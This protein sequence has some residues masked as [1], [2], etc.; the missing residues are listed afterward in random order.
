MSSVSVVIPCYNYGHFLEE[1][2]N[3][4]LHDQDGVE[5]RVLIVDDCSTDDSAQVAKR[6]AASDDR[7]ELVVHSENR[8]GTITCNFGLMEW[9]DGDYCIVLS[10]DDKL[11]PG[12]LPRAAD[13]MDAHPNVGFAYGHP[14]HFREGAPLPEARTK[15]SGWSIYPG[16]AW[17]ERRFR[18][19]TG[20]ITSPEVVVRTSLQKR[21]GGYDR[22]IY[23]AS[24]IEMWMRLAANA[25]V[26]YVRGADQAYYRIHGSNLSKQ[27]PR[28]VDLSQRK[29]AY[30]AILERYASTWP[31]ASHLADTVHRKLAWEALWFAA[32]AYD[33]GR[34]SETPVEDLVAFALDC[35]P[36]TEKMAAY[37]GLRLRQ[38]IGPAAMPYLQ[39]LI[40]TAVVRKA[41]DWWW[42]RSWERHGV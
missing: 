13:L 18:A 8:G 2:V 20:C 35:W 15:V 23:H 6:I 33:R 30:D 26:G 12:A 4:A 17:I 42:W 41:Q 22:R 29:L 34:V 28:L 31:D 14:I 25:D 37:R 32:R 24:D 21:V 19:A 5:V 38:R 40:F 36:E 9:A 11:T 1:C 7:V 3:S 39:P 10:A 27:R 16:H